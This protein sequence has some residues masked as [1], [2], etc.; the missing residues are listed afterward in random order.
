[1]MAVFVGVAV[2]CAVVRV[3]LVDVS[4]EAGDA[5]GVREAG[6][7]ITWVNGVACVTGSQ[8]KAARMKGMRK[9]IGWNLGIL[10]MQ[11][12]VSLAVRALN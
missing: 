12:K 7:V 9:I 4:D 2:R 5:T 1:M 8:A 6:R 11:D 10:G 3:A